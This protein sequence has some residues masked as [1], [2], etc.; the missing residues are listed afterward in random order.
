MEIQTF[1]PII[2]VSATQLLGIIDVGGNA[3]AAVPPSLLPFS[4]G[5]G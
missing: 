2:T 3:A 4:P 1:Y 5:G